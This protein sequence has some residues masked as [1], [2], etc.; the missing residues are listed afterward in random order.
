[1][2]VSW[3]PEPERHPL[4]A[5]I[6]RLLEPGNYGPHPVIDTSDWVWIIYDG[7][8]LYAAATTRLHGD[9]EASL[10]LAGGHRFQEW[11]GLLDETVSK[12]A[13]SGGAN[14]LTMRGRVGWRRYAR[15]FGW[16]ALG[17]DNDNLTIFEKD[18]AHG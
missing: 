7:P 11:I 18:L 1:M 14:R 15:R 4:W 6:L 17:Q 10:L 5:D 9:G 13:R 16:E 12:W 8:V 3:L 2:Q